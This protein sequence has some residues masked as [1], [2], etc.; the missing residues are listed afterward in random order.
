MTREKIE[1]LKSKG[2]WHPE[3]ELK[4]LSKAAIG[5]VE[6]REKNASNNEYAMLDF[7][8]ENGKIDFKN[9]PNIWTLTFQRWMLKRFGLQ[10]VVNY[11]KAYEYKDRYE[12]IS[13]RLSALGVSENEIE[14]ALAEPENKPLKKKL[15]KGSVCR[16]ANKIS[17]SVSRKEAFKTAW[18]IV[19]AGGLELA[20]KG[21]SFGNRQEALKRLARY[22]PAQ[23]KAVLVPEPENQIDPSAIAVMVGVQNGKGLFKLGYVPRNLYRIASVLGNQLPAAR[24][25]SGAWGWYGKTTYGAR[26]ALSV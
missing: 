14:T 25:V 11:L 7:L 12:L 8:Y 3:S 19:K 24:V 9:P 23:I 2:K 1:F 26:V 16:I 10:N 20:V 21:V 13:G 4:L 5:E 15:D 17:Q 6:K 18:Q 22:N